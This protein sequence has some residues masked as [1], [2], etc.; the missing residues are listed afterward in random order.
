MMANRERRM[1]FRGVD[2][3]ALLNVSCSP[4]GSCGVVLTL[5]SELVWLELLLCFV[6]IEDWA[7]LAARTCSPC[8][9]L[10]DLSTGTVLEY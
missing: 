8:S 5:L 10:S 4:S 9:M 1:K 3:V 6:S 2:I 7:K